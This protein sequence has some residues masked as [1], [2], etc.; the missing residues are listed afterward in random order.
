[1]NAF[2]AAFWAEL[3]K[4]RRSRVFLLTLV[5]LSIVPV[6]SGLFMFI[7]QDPDRALAMGLITAKAQ[8]IAGTA[9]WPTFF[10]VILLGIAIGG[11][12]VFAFIATWVFGREFADRTAKELLALPV[13]R[14]TI[15]AAKFALI[16]I[17]ILTLILVVFVIGL[18][19]GRGVDLPGW[20]AMLA[21]SSLG[22]LMFIAVLTYMLIP[23]VAL[24]ASAGRGYLPP[25]AWAVLTIV[26]AQIA[27]ITGWGDWFPWYVPA[28]VASLGEPHAQAVPLHSYVLVLAA[29][30]AG[31][32]G[33]FAWWQSADQTR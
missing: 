9:D 31:A 6:V 33:T 2:L 24:V 21:W 15:V 12:I 11:A 32:A 26:L 1:M 22:S 8:I 14:H 28:L 7:L 25:L 5:A 29:F 3:L 23:A 17:W 13:Q 4:A 10:Q 18:A 19:V 16:S 30:V 20:S 27:G